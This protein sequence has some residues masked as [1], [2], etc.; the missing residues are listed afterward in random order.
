MYAPH[1]VTVINATEENNTMQYRATVLHGVMLQA[2]KRTNVDKSGGVDADTVK[3]FIPFDVRAVSVSGAAKR[4][5][6]PK[7]YEVAGNKETLWTLQSA[8]KSSVSACFFVRGALSGG[9]SY[10]EAL[11]AYDDVF[12]VSGVKTCDYGSPSMQHWE[13]G[14]I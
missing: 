13:V 9:M 14:G 12:R 5:V 4:F 11:N 7:V 1:V 3:L 2:A 10:T 6:S 8:G